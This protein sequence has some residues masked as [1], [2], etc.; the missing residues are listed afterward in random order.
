MKGNQADKNYFY[1]PVKRILLVFLFMIFCAAALSAQ[2]DGEFLRWKKVEGASYYLVEIKKGER[3][4][5]KTETEE[6]SIP[7]DLIPGDYLYKISI[8][9]KFKKLIAESDWRTLAIDKELQPFIRKIEPETVYLSDKPVILKISADNIKDDSIFTLS[10]GDIAVQ[11]NVTESENNIYSVEFEAG[12]LEPGDYEIAVR[13]RGGLKDV[14]INTVEIRASVKPVINNLDR[15]QL[16]SGY[17]YSDVVIT[18]KDFDPGIILEFRNRDTAIKLSSLTYESPEKLT[19]IIDL[20]TAPAGLYSVYAENPSGLSETYRNKLEV[21]E[22]TDLAAEIESMKVKNDLFTI[23]SG[24]SYGYMLN[25]FTDYHN[26]NYWGISTRLQLDFNNPL[27]DKYI[28]LSPFG[29]E[30]EFDYYPKDIPFRE[31]G[32]NIYFKSRF[33]EPVNFIIRGGAGLSIFDSSN[34]G[35]DE[36]RYMQGTFGLAVKLLKFLYFDVS[37]GPKIWIV[38]SDYMNYIISSFTAGYTF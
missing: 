16:E 12:K 27:F 25:N 8:F 29:A 3:L 19:A 30:F 13:S 38:D 14:F 28:W 23:H 21:L 20:T 36:G 5:Q 24:F 15:K 33:K 34:K 37:A 17:V 6:A 11:G 32:M 35:P 9:N 31:I 10:E 1:Y 4:V 22:K 7:L 26:Y 18:G 2:E